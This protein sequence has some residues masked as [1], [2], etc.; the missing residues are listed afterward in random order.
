VDNWKLVSQQA[1]LQIRAGTQLA[2]TRVCNF[3]G[4]IHKQFIVQGENSYFIKIDRNYSYNA[5][6]SAV[7]IDRMAGD[8]LPEELFGIP[9]MADIEYNPPE[10]PDH[11]YDNDGRRLLILW[12]SLNSIFERK[13]GVIFQRKGRIAAYQA[14]TEYAQRDQQIAELAHSLKWR[15]NQWDT[16]QRKEH[17]KIMKAGFNRLVEL[18]PSLKKSIESQKQGVPDAIKNWER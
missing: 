14:A 11:F 6:L 16:Q 15:L 18:T 17:D 1:E 4:G 8:R 9:C 7:M 5:I 12:N 3:W 13:N 2:S 10:I